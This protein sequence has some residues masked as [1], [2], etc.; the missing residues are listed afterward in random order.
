MALLS[1]HNASISFGGPRL[2]DGVDLHIERGDRACLVGRNGTGKTTL[3]KV[4]SGAILPDEGYLTRQGSVVVS[5]LP[6]NVPAGLPGTAAE[7]VR[8]GAALHAEEEHWDVERH[9]E[10]VLTLVGIDGEQDF[11]SL[12]GG[13]QRRVLLARALVCEPDL[14]LLDEPTNHLDI[15]SIEW[16][17]GFIKRHVPTCLFVTHD[18]SFLRNVATRI[19]DLDRGQLADWRCDY[20]TFLERKERLLEDE[21]ARNARF[22]QKLAEEE[23]WIRK[24]IR[25]RRTRNEGRVRQLERLRETRSHRRSES[26]ME[27]MQLHHAEKS[28]SKVIEAESISFAWGDT[29]IVRDFSTLISR[30]DKV[31][32]IGPNGCGKT[33]L[34]RLLLGPHADTLDEETAPVQRDRIDHRT[35]SFELTPDADDDFAPDTGKVV[36]GTKLHVAYFDQHR[37]T[38]RDDDTVF[39]SIA[40][41]SDSIECNGQQRNVFGYLQEFLFTPERAKAPVS[42]LSGGERNRL[43]LARLFTKPANLLV[44]DEPTNDLDVETLELLEELLSE[45]KG[46]VLLVSHDREFLNRVATS[47]IVFEGDGKVREYVGGYDDWQA[48]RKKEAAAAASKASGG[49]GKT[50]AK[51]RSMTNREREAMKSLPGRIER[52]EKEQAE[53]HALLA[54][55]E[56]YQ[57]PA[58]EI[59]S[60]TGQSE[61]LDGELEAAYAQW[62]DLDEHFG[63]G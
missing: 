40:N 46:T 4:L 21:A 36:R 59:R 23:I 22:D 30:G 2:L 55:P 7:V 9:V 25:A 17:E 39:G 56:F 34:L 54:T 33:T 41:G 35:F 12:S 63:K 14:L 18:R 1:L 51:T 49:A 6:Q 27:S 19:I 10:R 47:S 32:I 15:S 44:L 48:Q 60:L 43:L 37:H 61:K 29:P 31:G 58:D 53:L 13:M 38:L 26:R 3:M 42:I 11:V 57:R 62:A 20:D 52:M 45:F 50:R 16:L 8:E 24:G 5:Y 28:G